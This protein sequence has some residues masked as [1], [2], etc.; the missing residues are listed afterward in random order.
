MRC[1]TRIARGRLTTFTVLFLVLHPAVLAYAQDR[2]GGE[3][4]ELSLEGGGGA[5]QWTGGCNTGRVAYGGLSGTARYRNE[6]GLSITGVLGAGGRASVPGSTTLTY[7]GTLMGGFRGRYVGFEG[8][9]LLFDSGRNGI[10]VLPSYRLRIGRLDS[11]YFRAGFADLI[12]VQRGTLWAEFALGGLGP[13]TVALGASLLPQLSI[14][15]PARETGAISPF[16]RV[17]GDVGPNLFVGASLYV[18]VVDGAYPQG[19]VTVGA[20]P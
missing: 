1:P 14:L 9:L 5:Y 16:L 15:E 7:G 18:S 13:M 2:E 3:E 17:Q 11:F 19:F 8:G 4:T 6:S 12:P 10:D 20:R